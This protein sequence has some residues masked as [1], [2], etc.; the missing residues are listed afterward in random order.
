ME[1]R[2]ELDLPDSSCESLEGVGLSLKAPTTSL[3]QNENGFGIREQEVKD[4]LK[5]TT[6]IV[7]INNLDLLAVNLPF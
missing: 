2:E 7:V 6:K 5:M 1:L 3:P 4:K